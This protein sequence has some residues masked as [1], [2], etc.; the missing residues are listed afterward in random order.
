MSTHCYIAVVGIRE[1]HFRMR[2]TRYT[3]LLHGGH[4]V[5]ITGG[6]YD[7]LDAYLS[8]KNTIELEYTRAKSSLSDDPHDI[9]ADLVARATGD[10]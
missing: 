9:I 10:E 7:V 4:E 2:R 3:A 6:E 8:A 5:P 1:K